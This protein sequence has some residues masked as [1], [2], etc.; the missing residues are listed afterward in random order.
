MPKKGCRASPETRA[1]QSAALKGRRPSPACVAR[2][3]EVR[4]GAHHTPEAR[5]K[6]TASQLA[7]WADAPES[8]RKGNMLATQSPEARAKRSATYTKLWA[9]PAIRAEREANIH[10]ANTAELSAKKAAGQATRWAQASKEERLTRTAA[11]RR[12]SGLVHPTRIERT[13]SALLDALG[14]AYIAQHQ[15]GSY[16]VDFF[17][18]SRN[19]VIEADGHYWH[20]K[21]PGAAEADAKRDAAL[22]ALG[23]RVL[24][25]PEQDIKA[26]RFAALHEAVA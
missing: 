15:I 4:T 12:A 3:S 25:L 14:V 10:A 17:V 9:D 5:A 7:R 24:R 23:Y 22:T 6:M 2:L 26:G 11:M 19:L 18:P 16:T 13:V 1:K 8:K 21:K 20:V